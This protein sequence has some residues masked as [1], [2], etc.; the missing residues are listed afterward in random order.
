M[1]AVSS[2]SD[3]TGAITLRL[4][5]GGLRGCEFQLAPGKTLFIVKNENDA[6]G[7]VG[8]PDL[9]EDAIYIPMAQGGVNFEVWVGKEL[10]EGITVRVLDRAGAHDIACTLHTIC[11]VGTVEF[12]LKRHMELWQE[13]I[14]FYPRV[15]AVPTP[16]KIT[17]AKKNPPYL[18]FL[19]SG[20]L[21]L[22]LIAYFWKPLFNPQHQTAALM[23]L[24]ND[25]TGKL[26]VFKGRD[27]IFYVIADNERDASW[28]K[29]VLV[30]NHFSK[31]VKV[32]T[33]TEEENRIAQQI[34]DNNPV[35]SYYALRLQQPDQPKLLFSHERAELNTE[36]R[37]ALLHKLEQWL[38]YATQVTLIPIADA[39]VVKQARAGLDRLGISY[40]QTNQT[41]G[42]NFTIRGQI[43]DGA[44]QKARAFI[45]DFYHQWGQRYVQFSIELKD[46][47][48]KDKSFQY[49]NQ[50]YIKMTPS[51]WYFP[52][53]L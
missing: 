19:V 31:P 28:A 40:T 39:T 25:S 30:R 33:Y 48:F 7:E 16:M 2:I 12:A 49:G 32:A 51:H 15:L 45:D 34:S 38:P 20:T 9:P 41:A 23:A 42:T 17:P 53:T 8:V 36:A 18:I 4:L 26:H 44:L 47:P 46:D 29:Q 43:E 22:A 1:T 21:A 5:N 50:G 52:K 3:K 14:L 11:K 13:K 10:G 6:S 24:L 35:F 37:E 27:N